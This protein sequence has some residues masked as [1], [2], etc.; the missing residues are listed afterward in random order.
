[1]WITCKFHILF[2]SKVSRIEDENFLSK[3]LSVGGRIKLRSLLNGRCVVC[4]VSCLVNCEFSLN[5]VNLRSKISP[6]YSSTKSFTV[7]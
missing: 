3:L 7:L 2:R 1:M 4:Q 6:V 5:N